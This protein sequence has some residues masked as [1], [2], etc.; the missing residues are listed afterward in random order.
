MDRKKGIVPF[1]SEE[2]IQV[3]QQNIKKQNRQKLERKKLQLTQ[4]TFKLP[5]YSGSEVPRRHFCGICK[6]QKIEEHVVTDVDVRND[7]DRSSSTSG[8]AA[9]E[10]QEVS[11]KNTIDKTADA[12]TRGKYIGL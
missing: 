9:E 7:E 8:A 6:G 4:E 1:T 2:L 10:R 5:F 11:S 12:I 3:V